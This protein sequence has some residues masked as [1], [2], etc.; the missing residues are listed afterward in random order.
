MGRAVAGMGSAGLM[1]GAITILTH[2]VPME[3]RPVYLGFMISTA[4]LALAVG[5]LIG[6]ALTQYASWRWCELIFV[7]FKFF[8]GD[9]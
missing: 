1:N 7:L 5:P 3:K 8:P 9:A 6:G 4:Q 2:A